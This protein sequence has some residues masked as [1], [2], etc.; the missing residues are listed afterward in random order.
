VV[1]IVVNEH[2]TGLFMMLHDVTDRERVNEVL[3]LQARRTGALYRLAS[4]MG[5]DPHD[6]ASNALT[7]G[8]KELGFE[9]AFV[10][11]AAGEDLTIEREVGTKLAVDAGDPVFQQLFRET[12]ASSV[13]LEVDDAGLEERSD[14]AGVTGAFCRSFLGV[15]LDVEAG[16]YGALGFASRSATGPLS[17][18]DREFMCAIAELAAVSIEP[19]ISSTSMSSR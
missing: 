10:V 19:S 7:F 14:Q 2:V 9:S 13:L 4:K 5:V 12:I 17:G 16:R 11:T 6:Q 1:P 8:L 3:A 15:P 18:F